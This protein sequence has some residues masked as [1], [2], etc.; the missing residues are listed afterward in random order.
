MLNLENGQVSGII[1]WST[2][3]I[4]DIAM[5]FSGH[6]TV[7]GEESLKTLISE[8][9]KQGGDTW[10]KLFEQTIERA[11]ATPLAYGQFAIETKD[12]RHI[13]GAK[14]S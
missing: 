9:Q 8:Y 12:D 4:S 7:F 11:A 5:D 10:D 3:Q 13:E 14:Y 2:A 1:D 6:V